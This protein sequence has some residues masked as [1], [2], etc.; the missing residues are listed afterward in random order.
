M[1]LLFKMAVLLAVI[2]GTYGQVATC[3]PD[4]F[5]CDDGICIPDYSV[6]N[7]YSDC[8]NG[9]D[10]E[11]CDVNTC[12]PDSFVCY[13]GLCISDYSVCDG[14]YDCDYGEDEIECDVNTCDPGSFVCNNGTCITDNSVCDG[15]YDCD[16]GEDE[17]DCDDIEEE[18][19]IQTYYNFSSQNYPSFY[20]N[21]A[22]MELVFSTLE[23]SRLLLSFDF[24]EIEHG[25]DYIFVGDGTVPEEQPLL[26]WSGGPS[27]NELKVLST[28]N[29]LWFIFEADDIISDQGFFALVEVVNL[30]QSDLNCGNEFNCMNGVCLPN[31][32][33]C[34][35][36][37]NCENEEDESTQACYPVNTCDPGSFVCNNGTCITDNSVCDGYYDCDDGEDEIDCDDI[38]EEIFIQTYYNFSSQNY[39]SFYPNNARMELVFSTLEDSRLLLSFDFIEIEHGYDYIF[40]GDGTVP[41]EQPLLTWSGG[42]SYNELK[43]LSTGNSLWFIFEAD[44]IISDQGFFALVEVVNLTQ[45]DLNCGNEFN[46]MNGV[47]LPNSDVCDGVENCENEE[48]ESTQ[49]C[50]P[51]NTC[52]PGSFVCNNGTCITDNSVCDGYYDCDDGEDEIDCDDIEEEIFIQTYYN[53]SSQNYPSFYPNNARMELVFSTLEDS[54]LLLSFDFIEIEHGYDY[55]FVGDGTVPEEQPLLTWSGGPSYNE[56]KV[57]STGNSLWFIFEADD[58]ISDQGFFALVEV[59]NL[60]QSDLNCGNEFNCMN[61]VCLPNSDV[62]DGVENCENDEDESTQACYPVNTCDPDSFVCYDG[63]CISDYSVCDGYYDCY[64]GEDEEE[65]A[66]NTCDPDSFV[67]YDGICISDYSVCDGYYECNYGEDEIGC[68]ANTCDPDSFVCYDGTCIPAYWFCDG[69]SDCFNG[70]DEEECNVNTCDPDS[71]VCYNGTCISEYSVCDGYYDCDYGEDEIGCDEEIFITTS[72]NFTSLNYPFDYPNDHRTELKFT[73]FENSRLL[74]SLDFIEIEPGWDFIFV[75]NGYKLLEQLLLTWSGGPSYNELKVLSTENSMWFI[76]DSDGSVTRPG[77]YGSIE[78]VPDSQTDLNCGN[79][80]NCMNGVCLPNSDVCDGVENCENEEDE[81]IQTCYSVNTC[82]PGSFVCNNGT[83]I[84]D[85]SVCDGYYDCDYGEDEEECDVNTCDPESFVCYDGNCISDYSVCDGYYDCDYG[86]D[87]IGCDANTCDPDS[88]VCYDGTCIPAYWFCDGYSDCDY[89]EDEEE[90]NVNTCDPGS[91]VC[92]NGTCITDNSVCDGYYDCYYGEDEI[93][94][95]VNTCDPE[96]FVCYDGICISAY[97]VCDGYYDCNYGE[98]EIGCDV[99]TCYPDSFVCYDGICISD[100]SVCD[101][102]YDCN[103]GE[104]E[105]GCDANTCDPDSFV[106]YDGTC[107]PAYWFCDGYSD[108]FNGEDEEECNVNTC[109]PDSFVCYNGTCISEYSVCDGYY[110]CDYGED[111]IGCDANTCDQDSFVCYDGTCIPAYWFCDG[112]SDCFNGEDEEECNVNTC[113]PGSFVCNNGTCITDNSVC[114]GYY[115]CDYGEDEI[116]CDDI[117]EEIF[118][119]TYYNFSSLNYPSFYPNNARMELVFSTLEDSRLLLSF[120]FIEIEHRFDYIFVGDGT[121]PEEQ[122]ILTWSGG[123]SYNELKVLSTGNSLWFIFESDYSIFYQ[124][125][126]ALVEVVNLT[127]SDLNCGNEFNCMNGVCLPNSDVCDGVEN[128]ENDEDEST[129]ACYPEEIFITTS[130]NFTSLNYPFDYP[131]NHR[132]ELKFTTFENSRLIMSFDF[133]EIERRYDFIYVGNGNELLEQLLLTWSGGPSYNELKVLSTENSMWLIFD[134]DGSVTRPGFYGSIEVVP[135]S[136]TDLNCGN[137]F[138]CMNGVC[139]PNSDVCDGVENCE[140]DED[141]SI[142]TC[143]SVNTCDPGSFVCNNGICITDNSVCD[144][145]YDCDYGEDEIDCD[146]IEEEIFIQTY[147]NFSS[148]N[149]PSFYPNNARMELVFSTLEDSRLLLSFDFIEIENGYDYIF[150]GEGTVPEEQ[151]LLTWSGGP[152]YNELKVLSTGNSLWFIFEA[153]GIVSDQGFFALV[154]VVNLTQSD[155]NCGNE[156]NCMNGVCLPNSDVCDGVENCENDEDESTQA[157]YPVNTCDPGSFVC[158]DGTCITDN[159]VCDGYYDCYYGEDEVDCDESSVFVETETQVTSLLYPNDYPNDHQDE[160]VFNTYQGLQLHVVCEF[161]HTEKGFDFIKVGDGDIPGEQVLLSWSGGPTSEV[162]IVS[163]G[164]SLWFR[165]ETDKS[166]ASQGF[167]CSVKAVNTSQSNL[168]CEQS[169]NCGNGVCIPESSVCDQAPNCGNGVDESSL[170]CLGCGVQTQYSSRIVGGVAAQPGEW[171]WQVSIRRDTGGSEIHLCGGTLLNKRWVL[172][173]A[174]CFDEYNI[175]VEE[176]KVVLGNHRV[177]AFDDSQQSFTVFDIL[178]HPFFN[179]FSYINDIALLRLSVDVEFNDFIL[180]ACLPS[181]DWPAETNVWITGWGDQEVFVPDETLQEISVPIIDTTTCNQPGWYDGEVIECCMFCAG[182]PE[183]GKDSCQGDSGGPLVVD[184]NGFFEVIGI[185]SW[186]YGCADPF[187][188]GVYTRVHNYLD[189]IDDNTY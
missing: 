13:D 111:E 156:F 86:E 33:V 184:N 2:H 115:D 146:D 12:H 55:I 112:Y 150:V 59:V 67:C 50:Y 53:F 118:I 96:S 183:G 1:A 41:E 107:I 135:D 79:E 20:P 175:D 27:Y 11:E 95:D 81:S 35:G 10:E 16:D 37:E 78:V 164:N 65:C 56:L 44:D 174:H 57:L 187:K 180:P 140:N 60:T 32:D 133:I 106:C 18:I 132:T 145:Y 120:D 182:L 4:S 22:R 46:C 160:K 149:Y 90:C 161:I 114:D 127:Q 186:G 185:T 138:N 5:A 9:E 97:S 123:P 85:N 179:Q 99:N 3:D 66:V 19:F 151:P 169:Y 171:P 172:S 52:D 42:P 51:V 142:Q 74:M 93:E 159:S 70:E 25:Y 141:E 83:C 147:Y 61:G 129:Q 178:T 176:Y 158:N 23:D 98:D 101:G 152:S 38:E 34:D 28:G 126:S 167:S 68:D 130:Y 137:E 62:C 177:D 157:C 72:Y 181:Q 7:G 26:T 71:F 47:C 77:F 84:T 73:T 165:F 108:C 31:S 21:N 89:G 91:F 100:Y 15:Y 128:C 39:P 14:Y 162:Q 173:A 80:F 143:Y 24:I 116:D 29:S 40:V 121:V 144:G 6:C 17:I 49:A 45:S 104:D 30:T 153:D 76:F 43:V 54:R 122:P 163:S 166:F 168:D 117:E 48:D 36:V 63:I 131:N 102:Y 124:G 88:F 103:Y 69:Y 110:D 82:D 154:E 188:P 155:L 119:Q 8:G 170:T 58:I 136:Q 64:Y 113:D 134:S 92:N 125:F 148:L 75:G 87:E 139:L 105:I 189:W 109:D 94:C